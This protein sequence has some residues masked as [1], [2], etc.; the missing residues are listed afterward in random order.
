MTLDYL[1]KALIDAFEA[2]YISKEVYPNQSTAGKIWS[3]EDAITKIIARLIE[4]KQ[5]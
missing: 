3:R 2:G 4:E 5:I 1:K